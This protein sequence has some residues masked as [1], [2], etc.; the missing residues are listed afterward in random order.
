[1]T[2]DFEEIR[3]RNAD[4]RDTFTFEEW[5]LIYDYLLV[6]MIFLI[7]FSLEKSIYVLWFST[8]VG[9]LS[10]IPSNALGKLSNDV[11]ERDLLIRSALV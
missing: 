2:V 1:E 11:I 7:G 8:C 4:R 6:Y 5:R 10:N 3:V 9:K